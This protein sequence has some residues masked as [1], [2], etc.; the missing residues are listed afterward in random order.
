MGISKI[1]KFAVQALQAVKKMPVPAKL[2]LAGTGIFG[3]G[4]V[5][6]SLMVDGFEKEQ[7]PEKRDEAAEFFAEVEKNAQKG[8]AKQDSIKAAT[9]KEPEFKYVPPKVGEN[10]IVK[11]DT[12]MY[13][14]TDKI[15]DIIYRDSVGNNVHQT[16]FD[17]NG[18][19]YFYTTGECEEFRSG[20]LRVTE[21]WYDK[22]GKPYCSEEHYFEKNGN[23]T[24]TKKDAKGWETS[25]E[26]HNND[27]SVILE[28][29]KSK[30]YYDKN[31]RLQKEK[32]YDSNVFLEPK[33][34]YTVNYK[35]N[36]DGDIVKRDTVR[37]EQ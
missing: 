11:A 9:P 19:L 15:K 37:N 16:S 24:M 36:K 18:N 25:R 7:K 3:A 20:N 32:H 17:R 5:T 26:T 21:N 29:D 14:G 22:D 1:T 30:V 31:G 34:E 10:G 2:V 8:K 33:L 13:P 23:Y 27:G 6:G 28:K 35:Y 12:T 4:L